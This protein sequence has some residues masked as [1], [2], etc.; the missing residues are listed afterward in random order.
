MKL[1]R[2]FL[3]SEISSYSQQNWLTVAVYELN[4]IRQK[5]HHVTGLDSLSV[6]NLLL[7]KNLFFDP[8]ETITVSIAGKTDVTTAINYCHFDAKD[9]ILTL[10]GKKNCSLMN[11]ENEGKMCFRFFENENNLEVFTVHEQIV[12]CKASNE[13]FKT[14]LDKGS[15]SA[16][17]DR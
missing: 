8:I 13:K 7:E 9:N 17:C 3:H 5:I 16:K 12:S 10:C 11:N 6:C 4:L 14:T 2:T 15:L 1:A